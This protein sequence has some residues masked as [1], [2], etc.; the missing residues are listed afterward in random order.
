MF[1]TKKP[2]FS[3]DLT[4]NELSNIPQISGFC[5]IEL[6]I[7]D[8]KRSFKPGFSSLKTH[9]PATDKAQSND[10]A[11]STKSTLFG[12]SN[13]ELNESSS[14]STSSSGNVSV[15]TS[16]K[17]IHNF[18]CVF[19]YY[20]S[21][22]LK[23]PFKR[24]ENLIANK[25]LILKIY[26]INDISKKDELHNKDSESQHSHINHGQTTELGRVEIN[27]SEYL[28]FDKPKTS[29]YLLK[30][31]KVNS[32][33]SLTILLNEL[34][35]NYDFHT[36]LQIKDSHSHLH[37]PHPHST[38]HQDKDKSKINSPTTTNFNVPQ[39]ERK[40]VFGG[41]ND[42]IHSPKSD[43]S[44]SSHLNYLPPS[45]NVSSDD[46]T[47]TIDNT[48]DNTDHNTNNESILENPNN[49]KSSSATTN[50][51]S[52]F[53]KLNRKPSRAES[54]K[55]SSTNQSITS[56]INAS[57]A[58]NHNNNNNNTNITNNNSSNLQALNNFNENN[59]QQ[60]LLMDPII[61]TLYQKI[62]ESTWDP[63]L[64]KLLDYSPEKCIDDIFSDNTDEGFN[65]LL[66]KKFGNWNEINENDEG[67]IREINGLISETKYRED[68][69]S[70]T[71][72]GNPNNDD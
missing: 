55:S 39:F 11:S 46:M 52:S 6:H 47:N 71:I 62:L 22:N 10:A 61:S 48:N 27:L 72:G 34:P 35:S 58:N 18:K 20:L 67:D 24:R 23:F 7:T 57:L 29:K 25:Y 51:K 37:I 28:N 59:L 14:S 56:S 66:S 15:T 2:K 54:I 4:I 63:E 68:L 43:S 9:A 45:S 60:N 16:K 50:R 31:S 36:Q 26:C 69:K 38:D 33:L 44:T 21:C 12:G 53:T 1:S 17:K 40:K 5:F 13:S 70:W 32:I 49:N 41:L 3:L 8:G 42:V 19:N 64:H 30:D 65:K